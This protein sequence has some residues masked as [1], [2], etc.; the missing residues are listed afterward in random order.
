VIRATRQC[1]RSSLVELEPP[2]PLDQFLGSPVAE[3]D[4][5]LF[6][7]DGGSTVR[8]PA[9]NRAPRR[10]ILFAGPE[11]GFSDAERERLASV[12]SPLVLGGRVLRAETAVMA[13]LAA[14]HLAC[15]DFRSVA[16]GLR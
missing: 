16:A 7:D 8:P 14:V 15:G 12:A 11:G 3:A 5:A 9:P 2:V 4:L 6:L 10:I 13:G 1:R